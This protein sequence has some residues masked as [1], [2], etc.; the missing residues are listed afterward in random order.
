MQKHFSTMV[1]NKEHHSTSKKNNNK[2]NNTCV[3]MEHCNMET[4]QHNGPK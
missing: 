1:L 2:F 3:N 4:F